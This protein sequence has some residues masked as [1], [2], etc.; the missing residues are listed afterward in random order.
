M[1]EAKETILKFK[2]TVMV[3]MEQRHHQETALELNFGSRKLGFY[4]AIIRD[5]ELL[6]L[7]KTD[8]R[9]YQTVKMRSL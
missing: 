4:R 5:R 7:K 2:P 9:I 1:S 3:E 8:R 6:S